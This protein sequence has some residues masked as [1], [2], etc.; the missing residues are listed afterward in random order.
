MKT[1]KVFAGIYKDKGVSNEDADFMICYNNSMC[2]I[3]DGINDIFEDVEHAGDFSRYELIKGYSLGVK[4][5]KLTD[6][7]IW[8]IRDSGRKNSKD[9]IIKEGT[10]GGP[11]FIISLKPFM[12]VLS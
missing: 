7:C 10:F 1:E 12:K 5:S 8:Q 6:E 9:Y 4:Q 3:F 2:L 11:H